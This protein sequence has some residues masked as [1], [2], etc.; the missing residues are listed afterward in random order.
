VGA[1]SG[2]IPDVSVQLI[3]RPLR[4]FTVI[5]TAWCGAVAITPVPAKFTWP[6]DEVLHAPGRVSSGL[7]AGRRTPNNCR[8]LVATVRSPSSLWYG[9]AAE[10]YAT[11]ALGPARKPARC[12]LGV[13][14]VSRH[15]R[16][17][18]PLLP[19]EALR[20]LYLPSGHLSL[21]VRLRPTTRP[22]SDVFPQPQFYLCG[23]RRDDGHDAVCRSPASQ[24]SIRVALLG[25]VSR[26]TGTARS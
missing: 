14:G 19:A 10:A 21:E 7:V 23:V 16:G 2:T 5:F 26:T 25:I 22:R 18:S 11:H 8:Q 9:R 20:V 6:R 4:F 3:S 13:G 12:G 24:R 17:A 1:R 15:L